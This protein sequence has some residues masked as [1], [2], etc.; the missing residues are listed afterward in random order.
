MVSIKTRQTL[1]MR[2]NDVLMDRLS[3]VGV[4]PARFCVCFKMGD[5]HSPTAN[6]QPQLR[7]DV[8]AY[9]SSAEELV[10]RGVFSWNPLGGVVLGCLTIISSTLSC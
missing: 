6:A 9:T 3:G 8:K 2:R 5:G 7:G 1:S 10:G 4:K